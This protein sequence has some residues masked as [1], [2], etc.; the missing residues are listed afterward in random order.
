MNDTDLR[1]T[2]IDEQRVFEGRLVKVSKLTVT[3]PNGQ[4]ATREVVRHVG[5]SAV[6]PVDEKGRVYLV[7]QFRAAMDR[8]MLEIPAG[9]LDGKGE[10]RLIAAKRE[11][12]E[13]TGLSAEKWTHLGDIVTT[14]GFT[15]EVISLYLAEGLHQG[16][17]SPDEDE[18]LNV[19]TMDL[20]EAV[21]MCV[22]GQIHDGKTV[23]GL[24]MAEKALKNGGK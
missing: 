3:L 11:L 8:V 19:V 14:P 17:Q 10:D 18:F 21:Q 5:A 16:E 23:C 9:K 4:P 13:E 22:T 6:V 24:L 15:D 7:R 2:I 1:E 20:E 12:S